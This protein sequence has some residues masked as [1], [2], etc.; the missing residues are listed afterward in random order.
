MKNQE[1][2]VKETYWER[3]KKKK[4]KLSCW[5]TGMDILSPNMNFTFIV[6]LSFVSSG[7]HTCSY[8]MTKEI[9][10]V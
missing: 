10:A 9:G 4:K 6:P 8:R 1:S 7:S 5:Q 3:R 2:I